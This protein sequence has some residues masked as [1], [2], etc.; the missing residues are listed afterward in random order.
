M[1]TNPFVS[2]AGDLRQFP[3][4]QLT[5]DLKRISKQRDSFRDEVAE[6]HREIADLKTELDVLKT[7]DLDLQSPHRPYPPCEYLTILHPSSNVI[8]LFI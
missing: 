2:N 6:A 8:F 1:L 3:N 4:T 7:Q 5:D